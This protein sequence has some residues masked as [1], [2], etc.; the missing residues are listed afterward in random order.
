MALTGSCLCPCRVGYNSKKKKNT[1]SG[2]SYQTY[3]HLFTIA[4]PPLDAPLNA[5]I[6]LPQFK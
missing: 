1:P 6:G 5:I 2:S 4:P 3:K